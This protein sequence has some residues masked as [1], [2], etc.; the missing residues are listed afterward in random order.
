MPRLQLSKG[1]AASLFDNR[2]WQQPGLQRLHLLGD[3]CQ[4]ICRAHGVVATTLGLMYE[5]YECMK[6]CPCFPRPHTQ[7]HVVTHLQRHKA[8]SE[9]C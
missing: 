2:S 8:G 4:R 1:V 9:N 5:T 7:G 6:G 3:L